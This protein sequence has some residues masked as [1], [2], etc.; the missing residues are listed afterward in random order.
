MEIN[1]RLIDKPMLYGHYLEPRHPYYEPGGEYWFDF[2]RLQ[3]HGEITEKPHHRLIVQDLLGH[4]YPLI[5]E[6]LE[7][8]WVKR[9]KARVTAIKMSKLSLELIDLE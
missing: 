6:G 7:P 8:H 1:C 3:P 5:Y 9:V 4:E 2:I